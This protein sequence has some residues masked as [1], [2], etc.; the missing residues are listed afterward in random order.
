MPSEVTSAPQQSSPA[1]L[2]FGILGAA[3]IG[4]EGLIKP[5]QSHPEVTVTAVACRDPV[6][7]TRYAKKWNIPKV[8]AGPQGYH[9]L[10]ADPDV[11]AFLTRMLLTIL[12]EGKGGW[13]RY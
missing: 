3:R 8:Y 2:R 11:D 1:P 10:I 5:A 12:N 13:K 4:P 9:E 6:R 7:G